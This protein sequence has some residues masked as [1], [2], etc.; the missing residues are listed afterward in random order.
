VHRFALLHAKA[1]GHSDCCLS[2]FES[3]FYA[4][5]HVLLLCDNC[6]TCFYVWNIGNIWHLAN[7]FLV[8]SYWLLPEC[9]QHLAQFFLPS[10]TADLHDMNM[11]CIY[12]NTS[13]G[14]SHNSWV[15]LGVCTCSCNV[16]DVILWCSTW[17]LPALGCCFHHCMFVY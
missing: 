13:F 8:G 3:F 2:L 11:K 6:E 10:S 17:Q 12:L 7:R 9:R 5:G 1:A 14:E 16:C 4:T 15:E